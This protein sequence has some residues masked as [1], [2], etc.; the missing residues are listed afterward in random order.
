M[1]TPTELMQR[2]SGNR[3]I[4]CGIA[5]KDGAGSARCSDCWNARFGD[6]TPT[7]PTNCEAE[8]RAAAV[9]Y[10]HSQLS[11]AN[12][13]VRKACEIDFYS[14]CA[15]V[16]ALLESELAEKDAKHEYRKIV[17]EDLICQ[18]SRQY[19]T[20]KDLQST[21]DRY[22][23]ALKCECYCMGEKDYGGKEIICGACEALNASQEDAK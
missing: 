12:E 2:M 3:C 4:D 8:D 16:R 20:I 15:Y 17:Q 22:K 13:Y 18:L 1:I 11:N 23:E 19:D 9:K 7:E 5:T 21:V 14:G 6:P 10:A